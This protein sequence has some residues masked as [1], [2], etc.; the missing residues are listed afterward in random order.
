MH[1]V[2]SAR[3]QACALVPAAAAT[4]SHAAAASSALGDA[5]SSLSNRISTAFRARNWPEGTPLH[6]L[7]NGPDSSIPK[8]TIETLS[9]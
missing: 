2:A 7:Q 5:A 3:G 6:E 4:A 9:R 8:S 1:I